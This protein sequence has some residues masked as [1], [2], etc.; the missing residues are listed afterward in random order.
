MAS[1]NQTH[2]GSQRGHTGRQGIAFGLEIRCLDRCSS[3]GDRVLEKEES[4]GKCKEEIGGK[5]KER[6]GLGEEKGTRKDEEEK[7]N[8]SRM[9]DCETVDRGTA[10]DER[11]M[12]RG[13]QRL[14]EKGNEKAE[15]KKVERK[16]FKAE[17]GRERERVERLGKVGLWG[18][19]EITGG[20]D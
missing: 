4:R 19:E 8:G 9:K 14:V 6:S 1:Q 11:V 20:T 13:D 12:V 5:G 3:S 16:V 2:Q 10:H 7:Q 18:F 15:N 17:I